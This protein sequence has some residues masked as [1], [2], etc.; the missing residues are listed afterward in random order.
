[1]T[2]TTWLENTLNTQKPSIISYEQ[3]KAV[4]VKQNLSPEDYQ[5]QMKALAKKLGV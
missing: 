3:Q 1:L 4:I 2:G 5:K